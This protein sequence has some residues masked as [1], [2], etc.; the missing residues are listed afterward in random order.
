MEYEEI[1]EALRL[2]GCPAPILAEVLSK[3]SS[4]VDGVIS[5]RTTSKQIAHAVC[6]VLEKSP[7]TVFPDKPQ[8]HYNFDPDG[9]REKLVLRWKKK[10]L[11]TSSQTAQA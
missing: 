7:E 8:Y 5:R 9:E 11:M 10:L 3:S 6:K 4:A 1:K 2:K